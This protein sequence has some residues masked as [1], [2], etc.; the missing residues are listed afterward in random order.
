MMI[1][2]IFLILA[3]CISSESL[4][5]NN[6]TCTGILQYL[7]VDA[8]KIKVKTLPAGNNMRPCVKWI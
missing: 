1:G 6:V 5:F 3:I 4:Q 7:L 2:N 8:Q